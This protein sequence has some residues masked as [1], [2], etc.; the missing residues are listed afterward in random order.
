M[1]TATNP[2]PGR[3]ALVEGE[4]AVNLS[5]RCPESIALALEACAGEIG[6]NKSEFIRAALTRETSRILHRS[7]TM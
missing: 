4:A 5:F 3:P 7:P 6:C 2:R 1:T